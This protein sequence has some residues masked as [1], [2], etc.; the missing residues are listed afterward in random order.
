VLSLF[1]TNPQTCISLLPPSEHA[2]LHRLFGIG[3]LLI[4]PLCQQ[5]PTR[6]LGLCIQGLR[7]SSFGFNSI[8]DTPI[9]IEGTGKGKK[10]DPVLL[11]HYLWSPHS[12]LFSQIPVS[13][14][15]QRHGMLAKQLSE[16]RCTWW[17]ISNSLP[18]QSW[19]L[20]DGLHGQR[21]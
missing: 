16:W 13:R 21:P 17:E 10:D 15:R 2:L 12:S 7:N 6:D 8:L 14:P 3:Q 1:P 5:H 19:I 11:Y 4:H 9:I 18:S 20:R